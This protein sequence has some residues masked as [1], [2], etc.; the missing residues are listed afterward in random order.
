[1]KIFRGYPR[2]SIAALT[3]NCYYG[4]YRLRRLR[5]KSKH[6]SGLLLEQEWLSA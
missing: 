2:V 1:M 6:N 5:S 3:I 4:M